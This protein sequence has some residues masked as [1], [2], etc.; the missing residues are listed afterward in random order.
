[1]EI[2]EYYLIFADQWIFRFDRFLNL[3]YHPC[4]GINIFYGGEYG[5]SCRD[6]FFVGKTASFSGGVLNEYFVSVCDKFFHSRRCGA[7]SVLIV[8]DFFRDSNFHGNM[9]LG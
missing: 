1:M 4:R 7:Y 9:D 8:F 6:I 2:S 3:Y 5:S